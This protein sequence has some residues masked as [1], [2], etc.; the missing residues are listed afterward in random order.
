MAEAESKIE[1]EAISAV[2][3]VTRKMRESV[4][5][6]SALGFSLARGDEVST[7]STFRVGA[8]YLNL[9]V[10]P[11]EPTKSE[12]QASWGRI[13]FYVGDVDHIYARAV[14]ADL[15]PSFSPRN[16]IWGERYFHIL[17]PDGNEVSFARRISTTT[18]K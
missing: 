14:R 2:T 16:A 3:F 1:I 15:E 9:S 17:D 10:E 11:G 4:K 18:G 5:F 12:G 6:Y 8:Q 13:I 7:F